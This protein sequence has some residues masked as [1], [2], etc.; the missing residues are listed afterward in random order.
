M[1]IRRDRSRPRGSRAVLRFLGFRALLLGAVSCAP[2][3]DA[4]LVPRSTMFVGI[5]VSGSFQRD[6][7]YND[8]MTFTAHYLHAHLAGV[9]ELEQPRA[10]F[11][12]AIGGDKPGQPQAFHPIHD[13][14]GKSVKQIEA[15]L[16]EWFP[17]NDNL[18][19][20]SAFFE[21]AASL[22]KR[23]NLVLAPVTL[24]LLTDGVP[25]VGRGGPPIDEA[26]RYANIDLES[27]EYLAR[28]VTVRV[29]Y[30]NPTVAVHWE[31]SVPRERVRMW[32][33]DA[34]V[35]NGWREQLAGA[36]A[37]P[38]RGAAGEPADDLAGAMSGESPAEAAA[39]ARA[40]F[41]PSAREGDEQPD[42]WRW[43]RDNVDFRVRRSVL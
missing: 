28:N 19:D 32:T 33:V 9:G 5:D 16:R 25:D 36:P 42:L 20:F 11:V 26:A 35:M 27:L 22:V 4:E 3:P 2:A 39:P 41:L 17:P 40:G 15:D 13:F 12:G 8:A 10:L 30:P 37:E 23:Q 34:V 6:G 43:I 38:A 24:V 31:H 1:S 7:R 18:T 21:R 14:E 29:L